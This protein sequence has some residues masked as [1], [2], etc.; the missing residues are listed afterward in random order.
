MSQL[1]HRQNITYYDR[2][3][4]T[5]L[6]TNHNGYTISTGVLSGEMGQDIASIPLDVEET[7][8]VGLLYHAERPL[9][10]LA[11]RYIEILRAGI[12]ANPTV[13]TYFPRAESESQ[14]R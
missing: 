4:L 1:P 11:Q 12:E 7:M 6:L 14:A 13:S 3:T 9:S 8:T 10:P 5:N 2:G